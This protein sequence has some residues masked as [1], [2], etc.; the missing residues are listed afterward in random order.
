MTH[1][2]TTIGQY[3]SQRGEPERQGDRIVRR[4]QITG[5]DEFVA[6]AALYVAATY[7][8]RLTAARTPELRVAKSCRT[9]GRSN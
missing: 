7:V 6:D 8:T 4:Y 1:T 2:M 5:T 3:F 9:S